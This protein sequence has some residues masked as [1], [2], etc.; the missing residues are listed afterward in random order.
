MRYTVYV[1]RSVGCKLDRPREIHN[2]TIDHD[3][4]HPKG[5]RILVGDANQ[6]VLELWHPQVRVAY[7]GLAISGYERTAPDHGY[8]QELWCV[9]TGLNEADESAA[10]GET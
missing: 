6:I 2:A 10:G 8:W 4:I 1:Q 9:V 5:P 7:K 3:S